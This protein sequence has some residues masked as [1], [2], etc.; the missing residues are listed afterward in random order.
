[1]RRP[2]SNSMRPWQPLR[3]RR[4]NTTPSGF[5][6]DYIELAFET[7]SLPTLARCYPG[8]F[9]LITRPVLVLAPAN[10]AALPS[11]PRDSQS[12]HVLCLPRRNISEVGSLIPFVP[13]QFVRRPCSAAGNPRCFILHLADSTRCTRALL[14]DQPSFTSWFLLLL[15]TFCKRPANFRSAF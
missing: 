10:L 2:S 1:M 4:T 9:T 11:T 6:T 14:R 15:L 8:S 5:K 13:L 7:H 12:R 3:K